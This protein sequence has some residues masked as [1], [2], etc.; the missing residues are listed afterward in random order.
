MRDEIGDELGGAERDK[1]TRERLTAFV[2]PLVFVFF[3]FLDVKGPPRPSGTPL[4]FLLRKTGGEISTP[5]AAPTPLLPTYLD[6][7]CVRA[8]GECLVLK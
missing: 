8:G 2:T 6:S 3:L 5:S 1:G 7:H 4:L